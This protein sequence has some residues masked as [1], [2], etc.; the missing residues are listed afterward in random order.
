MV[1]FGFLTCTVAKYS[2]IS[3][4]AISSSETLEHYHYVAQKPKRQIISSA[5]TIK[6]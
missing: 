4:K 5:T 2:D 6:T 1:L 3:E